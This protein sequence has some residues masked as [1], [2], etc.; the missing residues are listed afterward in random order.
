MSRGARHVSDR[1]SYKRLRAR[2]DVGVRSAKRDSCPK[3]GDVC[4][5]SLPV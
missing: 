4:M 5:A 3:T 2:L 1:R